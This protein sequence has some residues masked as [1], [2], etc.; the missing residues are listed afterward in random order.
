MS[1]YTTRSITSGRAKAELTAYYAGMIA[2][3]QNMADD[4][5]EVEMNKHISDNDDYL[6]IN[7][8]VI[9]DYDY[10]YADIK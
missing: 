7:F 2:K 8:N 5:V 3:V 1:A 6:L 9:P 4:D 10:M